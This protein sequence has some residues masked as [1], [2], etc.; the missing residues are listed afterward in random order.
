MQQPLDS[1]TRILLTP[2]L[3]KSI[4]PHCCSRSNFRGPPASRLGEEALVI[5][6]DRKRQLVYQKKWSRLAQTKIIKA[7]AQRRSS[8]ILPRGSIS[9]ADECISA[10]AAAAAGQQR[11]RKVLALDSCSFS[12][13]CVSG[14]HIGAHLSGTI[15]APT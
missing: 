3:H 1:V 6:L 12:S 11:M 15:L 2:R 14:S 4:W 10:P 13:S 5:K 7:I 9:V 8:H